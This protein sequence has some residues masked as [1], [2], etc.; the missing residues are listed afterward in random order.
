VTWLPGELSWLTI[1]DERGALSPEASALIDLAACYQVAVA[2]GHL[3]EDE[4]RVMAPACVARG[5]RCVVTH[6]FFLRHSDECLVEVARSGA[7]IELAAIVACPMA[8]H[9][10]HGMTLA[11]ARDLIEKVGHERVVISSD[12]GQLYQ[13]WP[14]DVLQTFLRCLETVGIAQ[15]KLREMITERPRQ[16]LGSPSRAVWASARRYSL[17]RTRRGGT[18]L[19]PGPRTTT[20]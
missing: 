20:P 14:A 1:L 11:P 15:E 3:G 13:P 8:H 19:S 16:I 18:D 4:I 9:L 2:T 6:A 12:A 7:F 5:V 17:R 10:G